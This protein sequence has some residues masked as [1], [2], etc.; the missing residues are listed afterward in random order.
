MLPAVRGVAYVGA[1]DLPP[2]EA[3]SNTAVLGVVIVI[4]VVLTILEWI[5]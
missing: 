4:L 2:C 5:L 1:R 3:T